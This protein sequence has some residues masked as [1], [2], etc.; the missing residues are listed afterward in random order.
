MLLCV[1]H[2]RNY[3]KHIVGA[4]YAYRYK[5]NKLSTYIVSHVRSYVATYVYAIK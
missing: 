3:A 4:L 5:I 2:T 1:M